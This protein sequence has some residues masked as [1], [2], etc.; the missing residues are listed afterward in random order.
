MKGKLCVGKK[1]SERERKRVR[2][3]VLE[4]E[5]KEREWEREGDWANHVLSKILIMIRVPSPFRSFPH[6]RHCHHHQQRRRRRCHRR[7]RGRRPDGGKLPTE[8]GIQRTNGS[9]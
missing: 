4:G 1:G 8:I 7:R 5:R 9:C 3:C 6:H 2:V